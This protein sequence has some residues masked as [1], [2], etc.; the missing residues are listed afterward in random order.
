MNKL[1]VL[2]K[3]TRLKLVQTQEEFAESV[4]ISIPTLVSIEKGKKVYFNVLKK[5]A[6]YFKIDVQK[7]YEMQF[8]EDNG[9][10][11]IV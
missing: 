11:K 6:T 8:E 9:N 2:V 5:L 10:G 3:G 4:G 1:Q 7:L